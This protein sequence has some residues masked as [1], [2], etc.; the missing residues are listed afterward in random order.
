VLLR[1]GAGLTAAGLFVALFSYEDPTVGFAVTALGVACLLASIV[2]YFRSAAV[3][4]ERRF[5]GSG[6][7]DPPPSPHTPSEP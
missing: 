7:A 2:T 5:S 6:P 3:E 4:R 1:V